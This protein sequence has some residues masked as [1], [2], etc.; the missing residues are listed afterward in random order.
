M[1]PMRLFLPASMKQSWVY[2]AMHVQLGF[3][4]AIV[5]DP[6]NIFD[7]TDGYQYAI[8]RRIRKGIVLTINV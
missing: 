8:G 1:E 5:E 2:E 4:I 6:S 7:E 3:V